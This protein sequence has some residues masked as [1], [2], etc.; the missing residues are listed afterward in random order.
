[1]DRAQ[2]SSLTSQHHQEPP[3]GHGDAPRAVCCGASITA[4]A[5][6]RRGL[7]A[8]KSPLVSTFLGSSKARSVGEE[9]K[10]QRQLTRDKGEDKLESLHPAWVGT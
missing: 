9:S 10:A 2:G 7:A 4:Y 1:M 3:E 6:A 5:L 8:F